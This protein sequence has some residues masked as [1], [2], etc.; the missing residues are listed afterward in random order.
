MTWAQRLKRVFGIGIRAFFNVR[1]R[2]PAAS[3]RAAV[4]ESDAGARSRPS[5]ETLERT[6]K[7]LERPEILSG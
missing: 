1:F 7:F 5:A 3:Q 6:L 2:V 4:R